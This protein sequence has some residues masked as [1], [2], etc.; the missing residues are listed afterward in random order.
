MKKHLILFAVAAL[1]L[2]VSCGRELEESA[3]VAPAESDGVEMTFH[4]FADPGTR[5]QLDGKHVLWSPGDAIS[6]FYNSK[7]NSFRSSNSEPAATVDFTGVIA[8][9]HA[10]D[11]AGSTVYAAFPYNYNNSCSRGLITLVV[12]TYQNGVP[13][14]FDVK[15]FPSVAKT[16]TDELYFYNVCSGIKL[17]FSKEDITDITIYSNNGEPMTGYVTV[18]FNSDGTPYIDSVDGIDEVGLRPASGTCFR[19]DCDYYVP[20]LPGEYTDGFTFMFSRTSVPY[21]DATNVYDGSVSFTRNVFKSASGFDKDPTYDTYVPYYP[22]E[23]DLGLDVNWGL[24]NIGAEEPEETGY[25]YAWAETEP[26]DEYYWGTYLWD[27]GAGISMS[28]TKY[29]AKDGLGVIEAEDDPAA[30]KLGKKWRTP[31]LE[32]YDELLTKC[33]WT[34]TKENGV[35]GYLVK[36]KVEG[37]TDK[38]IFLPGAGNM[39]G[40]V[41]DGAGSMARYWTATLDDEYFE[42]AWCLDG[43][44]I[45]LNGRCYGLPIRPV[46]D[47]ITLKD[48]AKEFVKGLDIWESTVGTVESDLNHMMAEG[49]A[50]ENAHYIPIHKPGGIFDDHDGNQYDYRLYYR[51]TFNVDGHLYNS[52]EAWEVAVRGLLEMC[53]AQGQDFY[54][55]MT[56]PGDAVTPANG[57]AFNQVL[58]SSIPT[59]NYS[60]GNYS[61]DETMPDGTYGLRASDGSPV[62]EVNVD[63]V[64]QACNWGLKRTYDLE[65]VC[66]YVAYL[67]SDPEHLIYNGY[68]G[69]VSAMRQ[70]LV[71]MRIYKYLLDN[72]IN[73]NVYSAIKNVKF[74]F[75]LYGPGA[76]SLDGDTYDWAD[77]PTSKVYEATCPSASSYKALKLLNAYAN[78]SYIYLYI[79]WDTTMISMSSADNVPINVYINGDNNSATGYSPYLFANGGVDV[80]YEGFL[81]DGSNV[82]QYNPRAYTWAG[83]DDHSN[84]E[85]DEVAMPSQGFGRGAGVNGKYEI[86]LDRAQYPGTLAD[87]FSLGVTLLQ[88]WVEAGVLPNSGDMLQIATDK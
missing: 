80:L 52:D 7:N 76:M 29:N 54:T 23:I 8:D 43:E 38:S 49:T 51:W 59:S 18:G 88:E 12:P 41:L 66:N 9:A 20:I 5:T 17:R 75:D 84:W 6:V 85:W 63:F 24:A 10:A 31:T 32:D 55:T 74:D 77:F 67:G 19:T 46:K 13:D 70:L 42:Q 44:Q 28:L 40:H 87:N 11:G 48:F 21:A 57:T 82:A 62:K 45:A 3:V 2:A 25:Y 86:R 72:D 22:G 1:M 35:D 60:W 61:W 47:K 81:C 36:S 64:L 68:T 39:D 30:V 50:W 14:S 71:L 53:S 78:P 73:S 58:L 15:S 37:F 27:E 33:E 16:T 26:K 83:G 34:W 69:M 65:R 79:E 4:A 56:G